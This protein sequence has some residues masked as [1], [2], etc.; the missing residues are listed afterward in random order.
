[1]K[2]LGFE[3]NQNGAKNVYKYSIEILI[4]GQADGNRNF[5]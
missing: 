5:L 1:V 2:K 4:I 3:I